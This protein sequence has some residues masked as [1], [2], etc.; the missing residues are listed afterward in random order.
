MKITAPA[1]SSQ[2]QRY[3][4]KMLS[5]IV[6]ITSSRGNDPDSLDTLVWN[7]QSNH[8]GIVFFFLKNCFG[9][10]LT[11][12]NGNASLLLALWLMSMY[13]TGV[14]RAEICT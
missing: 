13:A 8:G 14:L 5:E 10:L 6:I 11:L 2:S 4:C 12:A 1:V 9:I 7:I 3:L